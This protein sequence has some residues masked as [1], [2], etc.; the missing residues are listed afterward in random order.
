[1]ARQGVTSAHPTLTQP[2]HRREPSGRSLGRHDIRDGKVV[3]DH[4][5]AAIENADEPQLHSLPGETILLFQEER[6]ERLAATMPKP[7][8]TTGIRLRLRPAP[9]T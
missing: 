4:T 1:M 7:S 5:P 9:R 3:S 6:G 8:R 2:R